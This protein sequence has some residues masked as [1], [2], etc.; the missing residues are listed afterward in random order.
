MRLTSTGLA[1]GTTSPAVNAHIYGSQAALRIESS[2]TD[3]RLQLTSSSG[4]WVVGN[5]V[6]GT[7]N[8]LS[9]YDVTASTE[10]A[11]IDSSGR[12]LVG[13]SS[14]RS[15][16]YNSTLTSLFQVESANGTRINS[17]TYG[18]AGDS[19]PI[20]VL[21]KHR[22]NSV[23]GTTVVADG[24]Q[25][26]VLSFQGSDGTEFVAGAEITVRVDGTPGAD[27]M[28]GRLVFST[29]SDGASSPTERM[30]IGSNGYTRIGD[31][32]SASYLL[33]VKKQ[34][35]NS[36]LV[37]LFNT[38][39]TSDV[40]GN[41]L[42][43][44]ANRSDTTNTRLIDTK[45]N[46]WILYSNGTVGG[47]SDR[48]L[49]KNIETTRDGYLGDI[50]QLRVVK[51]NWNEQEDSEPKELGLI[52]QE[53]EQVFPGLVQEAAEGENG[54]KYKAIKTS[55]LQYMLLKALQEATTKIESLEA[56]LTAAGI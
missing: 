36:F 33:D 52:A 50:Q 29:T 5:S 56:R 3:A 27:D 10:R 45:D 35:A 26:G 19:G 47:T 44:D 28:P 30:R 22:S 12:L 46:K 23:G 25:L 54:T 41:V 17:F 38:E 9:F 11:R 1:I 43:L 48:R 55:V 51:Y 7:G 2:N 13:T 42:F 34:V 53:V 8:Y 14:A 21:A 20:H 16:F 31:V 24:D 39:G 32:E 37:R 15:N 40:N 49:K 18:D 6:G 4:T